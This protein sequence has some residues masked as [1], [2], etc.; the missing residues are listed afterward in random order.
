MFKCLKGNSAR[1]NGNST[2]VVELRIFV[3]LNQAYH[4]KVLQ[5]LNQHH[6]LFNNYNK[7]SLL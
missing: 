2:D 6:I 7:R 1:F 4:I 5:K 3:Y